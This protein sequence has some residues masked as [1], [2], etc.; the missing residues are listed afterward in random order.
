MIVKKRGRP[1]GFKLSEETKQAISRAKRNQKHTQETKDKISASL[2]EYFRRKSPLSEEMIN[3]YCR[4]DDD[5]MCRWFIES[6]TEIDSSDDILTY[7]SL[8]N[9]NKIEISFGHDI[10]RISHNITP[11]LLVMFKEFCDE[12]ELNLD[13]VFDDMS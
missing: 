6:K 13:E 2:L 10:E 5:S 11:E 12:R 9:A 3:T 8:I 4:C 1:L 7:R